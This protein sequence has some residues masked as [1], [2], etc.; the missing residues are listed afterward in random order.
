MSDRSIRIQPTLF[1]VSICPN[2]HDA[3]PYKGRIE[4]TRKCKY[5]RCGT[6]YFVVPTERK[7]WMSM[8]EYNEKEY[9][10]EGPYWEPFP[11]ENL[12]KSKLKEIENNIMEMV[13]SKA[14]TQA[15]GA[16]ALGISQPAIARKLKNLRQMKGK[17][18]KKK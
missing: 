16:E 17:L 4:D 8:D 1:G 13:Y 7:N 2:C 6:G 12:S 3:L 11:A 18:S 9:W 14:I 5:R 10:K 15:I